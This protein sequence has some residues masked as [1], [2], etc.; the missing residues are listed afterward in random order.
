MTPGEEAPP[1]ADPDKR[2]KPEPKHWLEYAIFFFV[3][4]TVAGTGAA[5]WY[6]RQQWLT[7][8]DSEHR[9]LRAYVSIDRAAVT[10]NGRTL[11]AIVDLKNSGQTPAY[12]L[13]TLSR[14]ETDAAGNPF[15]P[16]PLENAQF[17]RA[18]IGPGVT[19]SPTATLEIP[20][21]NTAI[22]PELQDGRAVI[23]LIGRTEYRDAFDRI[24]ILDFRM[25]SHHREGMMWIMS[26]TEEGNTEHEKQ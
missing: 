4:L 12:E 26:P 8:L 21:G 7:A 5:A 23:Y 13:K 25:R 15:S 18:L 22:I 2:S 9:Q 20:A 17:H 19:I 10:L 14:L 3:I 16:L 6:T 1:S 11:T 24:W